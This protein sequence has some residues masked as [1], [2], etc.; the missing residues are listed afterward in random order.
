MSE[1][2]QKHKVFP[3]VDLTIH[4]TLYVLSPKAVCIFFQALTARAVT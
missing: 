4:K 3:F 2:S 1:K